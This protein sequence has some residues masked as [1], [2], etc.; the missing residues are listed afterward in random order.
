M[1]R[2]RRSALGLEVRKLCLD[3]EALDSENCWDQ[4][5]EEMC[6]QEA[7]VVKLARS[8]DISIG[9]LD[10]LYSMLAQAALRIVKRSASLANEMVRAIDSANEPMALRCALS[11]VLSYFVRRQD[12]VPD[13]SPG[14][15]GYIDDSVLIRAGRAVWSKSAKA[16]IERVGDELEREV[17]VLFACLSPEAVARCKEKAGGLV[18]IFRVLKGLPERGLRESYRTL[19]EHPHEARLPDVVDTGVQD[20]PFAVD[21][22]ELLFVESGHTSGLRSRS[23]SWSLVIPGGVRLTCQ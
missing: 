21:L 23:R 14:G 13:D 15:Y 1:P 11:G 7:A 4:F 12:I 2:F 5:V 20:L 22:E 8:I 3:L 18:S 19:L 17:G 10:Q 16:S 9:D 6:G